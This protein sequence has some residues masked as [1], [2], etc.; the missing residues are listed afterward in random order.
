MLGRILL[1]LAILLWIVTVACNSDSGSTPLSPVAS[2]NKTPAETTAPPSRSLVETRTAVSIPSPVEGS[3]YV[4]PDGGNNEQ[5]TGLADGPYSGSGTGQPCAWDHPFRAFPP[6]GRPRIAGGDTLIVAS[7]SYQMG[8]GA[9]G[10]D[11]CEQ[12]GSFGCHMP[13]IPSG[14]DAD[15]PTR[16]LGAGWDAGCGDPPNCG[17]PA[18]RGSS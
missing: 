9:P 1:R 6:G 3:Y 16:I 12:E 5:C 13:P 17:V 4:R 7:G 11:G 10:S 14:S 8:Y 15:H 2:P 18:G